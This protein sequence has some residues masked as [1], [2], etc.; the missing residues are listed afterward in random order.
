ML[1]K[2]KKINKKGKKMLDKE[3]FRCYIAPVFDSLLMKGNERIGKSALL[4]LSGIE[5][6]T[7]KGGGGKT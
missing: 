2:G 5:K 1:G 4:V 3:F 7:G 6:I